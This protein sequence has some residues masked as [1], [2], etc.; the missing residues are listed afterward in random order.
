VIV[1]GKISW[2]FR[3]SSDSPWGTRLLELD[4][5]QKPIKLLIER[6]PWHV[7]GIG[8]PHPT[9]FHPHSDNDIICLRGLAD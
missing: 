7:N 6:Q 1:L 5:M 9:N 8:I 4:K 2:D 3:R